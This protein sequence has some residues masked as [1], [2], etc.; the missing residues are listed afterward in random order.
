MC[1][2]GRVRFHTD[3]SLEIRYFN[4]QALDPLFQKAA[5]TITG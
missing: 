2:P 5:F 3:N 4:T 1:R